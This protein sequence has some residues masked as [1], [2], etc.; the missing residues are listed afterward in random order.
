MGT[1]AYMS[2]EQI[3]DSIGMDVRSDL[4]TVGV[5]LYELLAG[6]RPFISPKY[7]GLIYEITQTPALRSE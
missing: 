2:P 5:I 4:F 1:P 3:D 6:S 7:Y